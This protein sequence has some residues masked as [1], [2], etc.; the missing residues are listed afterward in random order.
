MGDDGTLTLRNG[1]LALSLRPDTGGGIAAFDA[2]VGDRVVP[3]MRPLDDGAVGPVDPNRLACYPLLPWSNRIAHGGFFLGDRWLA[4]APNRQDDPWPIH[5]SGWQRAWTTLSHDASTAVLVLDDASDGY[6]YRATLAYRLDGET[7]RVTL[8][9]INAGVHT[10]P[11][12]L[13]LHP[14]FPIHDGVRLRAPATAIWQNDGRDPMPVRREPVPSTWDFSGDAILPPGGINHAFAGWSGSA[15]IV[16]PGQ[17]VALHVEADVDTY[18]MYVPRGE[19]FFCFEPVDHP[20]NAVHLPG[21]PYA[22]GMT[23]LDPGASMERR[24]AFRVE[25]LDPRAATPMNEEALHDDA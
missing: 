3:L 25:A 9:V 11:F 14:F 21:G 20:I 17:G 2:R 12:G 4:L 1:C 22:N 18:V 6:A 8:R 16:W 19:A 10:M 24:F 5:G 13:G 7:L 23:A 15:S